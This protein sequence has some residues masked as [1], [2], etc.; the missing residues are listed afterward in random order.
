MEFVQKIKLYVVDFEKTTIRRTDEL[1]NNYPEYNI[2][3][4]GS[5]HNYSSCLNDYSRWMEADVILISAFLSDMMGTELIQ[6]IRLKNPNA[7]IIITLKSNTLNQG[8]EAVKKG[9]DKIL[10]KPI[11]F[12]EL[13]SNIYE[14]MGIDP[15][16]NNFS[17]N[18]SE[19]DEE[20]EDNLFPKQEFYTPQ[21]PDMVSNYLNKHMPDDEDED[22][23]DEFVANE[24]NAANSFPQSVDQSSHNS[25]Q[26]NSQP[27]Q[28]FVSS[29][30]QQHSS[31]APPTFTPPS[32]DSI[33]EDDQKFSI[34]REKEQ[35]FETPKHKFQIQNDDDFQGNKPNH[36][37]VFSS[38][39]SS[40]KTTLLTNVAIAVHRFSQYKPKI[41]I[42]DFNLLFPS[43]QL[44]YNQTD[45]TL[46]K[47][48]IYELIE[49]IEDLSDDLVNQA[50]IE[51]EPTGI[52]IL[53]TPRNVLRA[54]EINNFIIEKLFTHL[55][56]MF[57]LILV[58]TSSNIELPSNTY[59]IVISDK[60]FI[61]TEPEVTSVVHT[62]RLCSLIRTLESSTGRNI[63][64][65]TH[66]V[67]NKQ[68]SK[69]LIEIEDI[70][71][72]IAHGDIRF[73]IP[74]DAK[75]LEHGN[76]ALSVI[77]YPSVST[78]YIKELARAVYPFDMSFTIGKEKKVSTEKKHSNKGFLDNLIGKIKR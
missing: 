3:F 32:L 16:D 48:N 1:F 21:A 40:G 71:S 30:Q 50:L 26:S 7:K 36:L 66:L 77:D 8:E 34:P 41:C 39:M 43:V 76:N 57:D 54:T 33:N 23:D 53:N 47:K 18:S 42:V 15:N 17:D 62:Q 67:L 5:S 14:V 10:T 37:V 46:A 49:D 29:N 13:V 61:I 64:N 73:I 38:A 27:F 75:I 59:P 19:E 2:K 63:L 44:K 25:Q 4:I 52:K 31:M 74:E 55:R 51:H 35:L 60:N 11:A 65:K 22:E 45:F 6:P 68:K 24:N 28:T 72:T 69:P 12:G 70:K 56:S 58:D 20:Q 9:A 78:K